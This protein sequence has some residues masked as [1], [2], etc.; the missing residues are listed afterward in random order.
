MHLKANTSKLKVE[1]T[2][3]TQQITALTEIK[4]EWCYLLLG[5]VSSCLHLATLKITPITVYHPFLKGQRCY[6]LCCLVSNTPNQQHLFC[7]TFRSDDVRVFVRLQ[8]G[9]SLI[10]L[11]IVVEMHDYLTPIKTS[12]EK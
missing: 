4:S 10:R 1:I 3:P 12:G 7:L 9:V 2:F 6:W 11:S 8:M 5:Q